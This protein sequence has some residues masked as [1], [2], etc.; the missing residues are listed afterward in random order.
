[1]KGGVPDSWKYLFDSDAYKG[2]IALMSDS[3]DLY[4]AVFKYLGKSVNAPS[5]EL[6]KQVEEILKKQKPNV[7][8]FHEDNGQDLLAS[9]EVDI[10]MEYNGDIAQ[11]MAEDDDIDF[12]LPKEGSI[13]QSDTLAIPKG[14]PHP[15]NAH[16]FI[17][18]LLDAEVGNSSSRPSSIP[19]PT[20][21]RP[22]SWTMLQEQQGDLPACRSRGQVRVSELPRPGVHADDRR[23]PDAPARRLRISDGAL[24]TWSF[25]GHPLAGLALTGLALTGLG[26][27]T[28]TQNCRDTWQRRWNACEPGMAHQNSRH[29]KEARA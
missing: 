4:R 7:K 29:V 23:K 16:K 3:S 20:Q 27:R 8:A 28:P 22:R 2:R 15:E 12:V 17:N 19:R 5:P 13:R 6:I 9:G 24:T 11:V 1:M 18:Y 25:A 10:V 21:P 26:P 14:A